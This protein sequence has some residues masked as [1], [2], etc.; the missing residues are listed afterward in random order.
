M[1]TAGYIMTGIALVVLIFTVTGAF[2]NYEAE[3]ATGMIGGA[4]G[5]TFTTWNC[6]IPLFILVAGVGLVKF[7]SR[8]EDDERAERIVQCSSCGTKFTYIKF[9]KHGCSNCGS[10]VYEEI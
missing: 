3:R 7:A 10:N 6:F 4:G 8:V 1:K 9:K 5:D 2:R